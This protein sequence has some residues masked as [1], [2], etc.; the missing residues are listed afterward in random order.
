MHS[1][2]F[3]LALG[4]T[5]TI[6]TTAAPLTN[7]MPRMH[8]IFTVVSAL[9][10][11]RVTGVANATAGRFPN[12]TPDH[13]YSHHSDHKTT[14]DHADK[15]SAEIKGDITE[16]KSYDAPSI[17]NP[18]PYPR[19]NARSHQDPHADQAHN[20]TSDQ[21]QAAATDGAYDQISKP[22]MLNTSADSSHYDTGHRCAHPSHRNPPG[23]SNDKRWVVPEVD[24]TVCSGTECTDWKGVRA[25]MDPVG[26]L[27]GK[28]AKKSRRIATGQDMESTYA[29]V[30]REMSGARIAGGT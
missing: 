1:T 25:K 7:P 3:L 4:F 6:T 30:A 2:N 5:M 14:T 24:V 21:D 15:S 23:H 28:E 22:R 10:E 20:H 16:G 27:T 11:I 17:S 18:S 26:A 9:P 12:G 13:Q 19:L 8:P 29:D